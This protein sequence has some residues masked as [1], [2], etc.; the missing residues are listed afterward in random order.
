M[1]WVISVYFNIRNTLPKSGTFLLGHNVY[2]YIYSS[3]NCL[4][5]D[6]LFS[7]PDWRLSQGCNRVVRSPWTRRFVIGKVATRPE[8]LNIKVARSFQTSGIISCTAVPGILG[9]A[10]HRVAWR[11]TTYPTSQR[12]SQTPAVRFCAQQTTLRS[13]K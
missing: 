12:P 1:F 11:I 6:K 2:I 10:W 9:C 8:A 5:P 7:L 4:R 13:Y 3:L